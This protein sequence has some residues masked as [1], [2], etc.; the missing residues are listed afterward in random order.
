LLPNVVRA[1]L[2][3][4]APHPVNRRGSFILNVQHQSCFD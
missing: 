4:G 1:L 2:Y 3:G